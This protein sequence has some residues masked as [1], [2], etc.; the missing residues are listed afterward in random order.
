MKKLENA[1]ATGDFSELSTEVSN[2]VQ[3]FSQLIQS[4]NALRQQFD[5]NVDFE[6]SLQRKE[7]SARLKNAKRIQSFDPFGQ[8]NVFDDLNT[9]VGLASGSFGGIGARTFGGV[10]D[11]DVLLARREEL[12][13]REST[14]SAD[15]ARDEA[16]NA[17]LRDV[18]K[19]LSANTDAL[20]LLKDDTSRLAKINQDLASIQAKRLADRQKLSRIATDE[21]AAEEFFSEFQAVNKLL[22]GRA[23]T[24][25][26]SAQIASMSTE[27]LADTIQAMTG[28]SREEALKQAEGGQANTAREQALRALEKRGTAV[29]SAEGQAFIKRFQTAFTQRGQS[30]KEV[31]L[32][33]QGNTIIESQNE[34]ELK[35]ATENTENA[36]NDLNASFKTLQDQIDAAVLRFQNLNNNIPQNNNQPGD[37]PGGQGN[38]GGV[39]SSAPAIPDQ[40]A[41]TSTN[42]VSVN[43]MGMDTA[44]E[45]FKQE[46][47][48]AI[49]DKFE[50]LGSDSNGR[51]ADPSLQNV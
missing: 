11:P 29:D 34:I 18:R 23:I 7:L 31:K 42:D 15:P 19:E 37:Q 25:E 2:M 10:S 48:N 6:I 38:Q 51:P 22:S 4:T 26:E 1:L 14:L 20:I 43:V 8:R 50:D 39:A 16:A 24:L 45:A 46:V 9:Q 41:L 28:V 49:S 40:I 5:A 13:A 36:L 35:L 47:F 44:N 21:G 30:A 33:A 3:G 17:E 27:D 12:R 32:T